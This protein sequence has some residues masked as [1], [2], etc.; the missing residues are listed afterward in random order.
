MIDIDSTPEKLINWLNIAK[1]QRQ[2]QRE[3][4][5]QHFGVTSSA[6]RELDAEVREID[7]AIQ[8]AMSVPTPLEQSIAEKK[9]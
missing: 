5:I 4:F 8:A 9:K 2:R 3:K 7:A 6:V 1:A